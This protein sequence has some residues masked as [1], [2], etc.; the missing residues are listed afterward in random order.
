MID[1]YDKFDTICR[2]KNLTE[3]FNTKSRETYEMILRLL[4]NGNIRANGYSDEYKGSM[5]FVLIS[6]IQ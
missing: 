3:V 5:R 6:I 1:Y 2:Q 4:R